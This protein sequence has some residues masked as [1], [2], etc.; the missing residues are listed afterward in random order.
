MANLTREEREDRLAQDDGDPDTTVWTA[1]KHQTQV[2]YHENPG[3][4]Q[5]R[6]SDPTERTRANA[7]R[8]FCYPCAECVLDETTHGEPEPTVASLLTRPDIET[9]ADAQ[10]VLADD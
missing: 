6:A 3:C 9:F 7:K 8:R 1:E 4:C 2:A 10:E 5:L